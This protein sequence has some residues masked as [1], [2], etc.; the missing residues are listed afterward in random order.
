[1]NN[2]DRKFLSAAVLVASWSKD[3]STQ[4]GCI[5]TDDD[6]NQLAGGFNGFPRGVFD[7]ERLHNRETKLRIVVHAEANAV[8]AAARNGHAL[9]GSTAYITLPPCA[10]C[11]SL[12]IQAGVYRVVFY[13][14][15]KPSKWETDWILAQ[16]LFAEAGIEFEEV[17]V[18]ESKRAYEHLLPI[19]LQAMDDIGRYGYEK[20]KEK[21]FQHKSLTG[22]RERDARVEPQ[23]LADHA[24]QHF[25]MYLNHAEHDYFHD[26]IHQLA[27]AS[28]NCMMEAYYANLGVKK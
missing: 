22:D 7:N 2:W 19:F 23:A 26:D 17:L 24:A 14:G 20:Y 16:G 4:V 11:A 21:S 6:H 13:A 28:F 5:I 8:S 9:K 10:Q 3:P 25:T 1:M 27:A 18:P 15:K 12:L